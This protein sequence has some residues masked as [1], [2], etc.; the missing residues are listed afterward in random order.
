MCV[1]MHPNIIICMRVGAGKSAKY[2]EYPGGLLHTWLFPTASERREGGK[3]SSPPLCCEIGLAPVSHRGSAPWG[4]P[5]RG[6]SGRGN[7]RPGWKRNREE[8]GC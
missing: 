5:G 2:L 1:Y 8:T 4:C 3:L 7:R 6:G